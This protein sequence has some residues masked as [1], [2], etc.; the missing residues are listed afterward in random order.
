MFFKAEKCNFFVKMCSD[1]N[2]TCIS[3]PDNQKCSQNEK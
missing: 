3:V 2:K 1:S